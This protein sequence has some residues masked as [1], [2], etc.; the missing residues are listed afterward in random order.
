MFM[1]LAR[2]G[3]GDAGSGPGR[4]PG[5]KSDADS[6]VVASEASRRSPDFTERF[7]EAHGSPRG[8]DKRTRPAHV[9]HDVQAMR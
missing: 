4:A 1:R 7:T 9:G 2:A 8:V 5:C 6:G 3:P